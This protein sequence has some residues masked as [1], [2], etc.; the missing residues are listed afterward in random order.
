[1]CACLVIQSCPNLFFFLC[2]N[3]CDPV[4]IACQAPLSM[5]FFSGKNTGVCC[6]FLLQ[7]IFNPGIE[8]MS[9]W[10]MENPCLASQ[11]A[12]RGGGQQSCDRHFLC[13]QTLFQAL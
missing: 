5:G 6:H 10:G 8:P 13:A 12:R 9:P 7:G 2:P 11:E 1:M 3:L 4:D